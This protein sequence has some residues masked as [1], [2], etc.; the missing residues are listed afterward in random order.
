MHSVT[1]NSAT[2]WYADKNE[3]FYNPVQGF[4]YSFLFFSFL[5]LS[6][7]FFFF[8]FLSFSFFFFLFLSS[9][10]SSFFSLF[11]SLFFPP[12]SNTFFLKQN[13]NTE[14]NRDLSIMV[15]KQFIK[16]R[17]IEWAEKMK[18]RREKNPDAEDFPLRFFCFFVLFF[19]FVFVY[20]FLFCFFFVLLFVFYL[21]FY[22][23]VFF[24][25]FVCCP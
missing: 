4:S 5:F 12:F 16:T 15:I 18:K 23:F 22:F 2:I 7:S 1:E 10:S 11:F 24:L 25:Y 9:S 21:F 17:E 13:Q 19:C 14:T 3:V 6:F 20:F 8:L